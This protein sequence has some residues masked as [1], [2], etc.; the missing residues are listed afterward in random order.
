VLPREFLTVYGQ[1]VPVNIIVTAGNDKS[2]LPDPDRYLLGFWS[3][4]TAVQI[5]PMSGTENFGF[6]FNFST[7]HD[8]IILTH[9]LHGSLVNIGWNLHIGGGAAVLTI[10]SGTMKPPSLRTRLSGGRQDEK[11]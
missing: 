11:S 5:F 3:V 6:G 1:P 4:D 10:L 9:A 7:N 2:I 8:P